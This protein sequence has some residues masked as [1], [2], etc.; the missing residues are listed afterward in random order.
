MSAPELIQQIEN[1]D[2]SLGID[3]DRIR[4]L[5]TPEAETWVPELQRTRDEVFR[6]LLERD[7]PAVCTVHGAGATWWNLV[8]GTA[9]CGRCHPDPFDTVGRVA[10][11]S[12]PVA[13]PAGVRLLR[14]AP[15][16][17][18]IAV[19]TFSVVTD[20]QSFIRST[21]GQL[22]AALQGKFWAA[23]NWSVRDLCERLEQVG[24]RVDVVQKG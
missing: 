2:G 15:K 22:E 3:G 20:P 18:P 1:L 7:H 6:V 10:A 5:L 23:G 17:P 13:M 19:T 14:W 11:Q 9:V 21:L 12:E 4:V 8:D 16:Q 24:V